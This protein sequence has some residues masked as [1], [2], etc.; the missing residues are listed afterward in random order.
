MA[1]FRGMGA[2]ELDA[3]VDSF[4]T[5][6]FDAGVKLIEQG[7]TG[8]QA[9]TFFVIRSG[10]AQA[11]AP[12]TSRPT[13]RAPHLAPH[14]ARPTPRA[15]HLAPRPHAWRARARAWWLTAALRLLPSLSRSLALRAQVTQLQNGELLTIRDNCG[16][17]DFFGEM[18]LLRDEPRQATVTATSP[19][20]CL[21][22]HR[23]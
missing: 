5:R 9:A 7:Q 2:C 4:E 15:P 11:R 6:E 19:M 13:P 10:S 3:L 23:D 20:T 12:H 1:L 17:G 16:S 22:L 18:A 21:I 14:T 8:E